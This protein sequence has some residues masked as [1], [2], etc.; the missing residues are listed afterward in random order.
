MFSIGSQIINL[1]LIK[2]P[3]DFSGTKILNKITRLFAK[4][5]GLILRPFRSF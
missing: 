2:I 1:S 3:P 5:Q 4:S